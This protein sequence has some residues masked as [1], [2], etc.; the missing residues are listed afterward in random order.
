MKSL[1]IVES[2]TKANTIKKFLGRDTT[3]L[4][5]Y[6]HIRDLP[7]S[8]LGVDP[9]KDFEISYVIPTKARKNVNLLKKEVQKAD[10]VYVATDPDREGEAIA[11][12]LIEVLGLSKD[13]YKRITFHEI[14][15]SAIEG[16]LKNPTELNIDLVDAQ[17]ARRVLD[18]IVGY[19]LS[20]L[21][22]KKVARGLSAGRVQS[23]AV[24]LIVKREEEI[25]AFKPEEYWSI[26]TIL[27][28]ETK[29][30]FEASLTKKQGKSI[31]KMDIKN[32]EQA[33]EI[34]KELEG[35]KYKVSSI[36]KKETVR[37]P[38]PPFTTSSLQQ[39]ASKKLH[40][41]S[42]MTMRL[43]QQMY[44][45]GLITYHRT[46]SLN[47]S[48]ESIAAAKSFVSKKYGNNY[49]KTRN[50]KT[51]G[52][53][54]E[55]HEA[56]RPTSADNEPEKAD[57]DDKQRK[58]YSLIWSRFIASQMTEA[59]F[60]STKAEIETE[61]GYTLQARGLNLKFDGYLKVY[62]MKFEEKTLPE[63]EEKENLNLVEIKPEQH[64]TEPPA[65][66]TEASL[67]KEMETN[68]IGRPSTY[69][70]IIS[71]IQDRNYVEKNKDRRFEPTETGKSVDQILVKHFP[72]I[73]DIKFTANMEK[74]L[75][76]IAEGK[77]NWKTILRDFYAPFEK[78]LE[79]KYEEV[80]KVKKE[81]I[82]TD[83]ICPKCGKPMVIKFGRF[84]KFLA[85]TGFPECKHTEAIKDEKAKTGI[86]C[87]KC[88]QGEIIAKKSKKGRVFYSCENW[89]DC[90]FALWDKPTGEKCPKCG[91]LMVE[92]G[93]KTKCS[94]KN[95]K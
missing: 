67:I 25:Q 28:K 17:Q 95:C 4:S 11:W 15:K 54:Q 69:A 34:K 93:K 55:A 60:D 59:V 14:T 6:G 61:N 19:K 94:N 9:E 26:S 53:A 27:E 8:K 46:D 45:R 36:E 88:E 90:D 10:T 20:P 39:E 79:K 78:N 80:E 63:L 37:N 1:V 38:L 58:L 76:E 12:H 50:F 66:Y 52:R 35:T 44:E 43:A 33:E 24:R 40:F 22:W 57:L 31:G 56:I 83:K 30:S 68:E 91:S 86:T 48:G 32:K 73:V 62:P 18:R 82:P 77:E 13:K 41:P 81:D 2:P 71:T 7:K 84:G 92:K 5:S 72:D 3:V 51:K 75:D 47:L 21:L 16:A 89:P 70:S 64:F 42:K 23:V 29:E 49:S 85:C 65:R 87:P 74:E